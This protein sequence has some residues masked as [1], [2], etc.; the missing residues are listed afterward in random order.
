M[1]VSIFIGLIFLFDLKSKNRCV[2]WWLFWGSGSGSGSSNGRR[3]DYS[4]QRVKDIRDFNEFWGG[5]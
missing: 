2:C 3:A 4:S 1:W 5:L